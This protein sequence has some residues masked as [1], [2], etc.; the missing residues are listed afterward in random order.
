MTDPPDRLIVLDQGS[1]PGRAIIDPSPD[2][3]GYPTL[4]VDHHMSEKVA[5]AFGLAYRS[6]LI[7]PSSFQH[8]IPR[9]LLPHRYWCTCF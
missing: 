2:V 5:L 7:I 3:P 4:I 1:R 9:Q 8:A 6:G